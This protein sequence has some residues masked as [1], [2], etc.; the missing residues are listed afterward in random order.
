MK[1]IVHFTSVHKRYDIRIFL[2]QCV[3][4]ANAGYDV[5]LV[6]ADGLGDEVK[7]GVKILD[8]GCSNS[9]RIGRMLN[10]TKRVYTKALELKADFYHFHDPELIPS[11]LKLKYKTNAVVVFDSHENY[12]DDIKDKPYLNFVMRSVVSTV[13]SFL[14]KVMV[15]KLDAVIAATPSIC[16]HFK[17]LNAISLDINNFPFESEFEPLEK[18]IDI[19]YSAVYIGTASKVRG[20]QELVDSFAINTNLNL[21]IAGNFSELE[22][23]NKLR[24]SPGW[25]NVSFLGLLNRESVRELLSQSTVAIV[26]FLPA[27]NHME[28]QPNKMFE[29]MSAGLPVVCSDFPLWKEIIE[30]NNCGICVNPESPQAIAKAIL[31]LNQNKDKAEEMGRNGR[32]AVLEKYNWTAEAQKLLMFYTS[33]LGQSN[34]RK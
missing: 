10:T 17:S 2:K 6:V 20:L 25:S 3:T 26:T 4:L 34:D 24:T 29:Y 32:K 12:A 15:K 16:N 9:G 33:L 31:Y 19:K 7:N 11:G 8:V 5:Y 30:D 21:A 28:S 13:Y 14:E 27:P 18:S 23:E 1:K 22:F